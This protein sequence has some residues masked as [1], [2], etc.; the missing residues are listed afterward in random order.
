MKPTEA[1]ALWQQTLA[2]TK[3][4]IDKKINALG[5]SE[6]TVQ[7]RRED[8][9]SEL[10]VQMPGVDDPARVKQILQTAAVLEL[11]DVKGGPFAS[12]EEALA[13]NG[14]VLPLGTKLIGAPLPAPIRIAG[15]EEFTWSPAHP[16]CAGP[17]FATPSRRTA[18]CRI[19]GTPVSYLSQD[20]AKR[21]ATYTGSHIG[22]RLA[23]VLDGKVL[24]APTIQKPDQRSR[25]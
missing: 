1:L 17:T 23:I 19:P 7:Q 13:Q 2:Q 12:R 21:F 6:A 10:L 5:L 8:N 11:Y 15:A 24:S 4:T 18:S 16:S 22:K 14:G 20:A 9:D 25:A 3:N